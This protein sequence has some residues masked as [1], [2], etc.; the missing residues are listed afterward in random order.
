MPRIALS[1]LCTSLTAG[2][3]L[4]GCSSA[5]FDSP[6]R[7]LPNLGFLPNTLGLDVF[8]IER[9]VNDQLFGPELWESVDTNLTD[10]DLQNALKRNGIR[11]G[12]V[13]GQM[14]RPLEALLGLDAA[15]ADV[16]P[17]EAAEAPDVDEG[18]A[19]P[20]FTPVQT[21]MDAPRGSHLILREGMPSKLAAGEPYP[22]CFVLIDRNGVTGRTFQD[23]HFHFHVTP[24]TLTGSH[25]KLELCPEIQHGPARIQYQDVLGGRRPVSQAVESFPDLNWSA[26]LTPGQMVLLTMWPEFE[27]SLGWHYFSRQDGEAVKQRLIVIRVSRLPAADDLFVEG[28]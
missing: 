5:L 17:D 9:P 12:I 2:A 18:P 14:P 7:G 11:I 21:M 20:D 24:L 28:P 4:V 8:F 6:A 26:T 13:G 22:K 27:E 19:G 25:V 23:A 10:L 1:V 16:H 3:L 15:S